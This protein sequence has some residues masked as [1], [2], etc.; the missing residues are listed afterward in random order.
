MEIL[1]NHNFVRKNK[2]HKDRSLEFFTFLYTF[3]SGFVFFKPGFYEIL[4]QILS[5][6]SSQTH[7]TAICPL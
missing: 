3:S 5:H 7:P 1:S 4:I 6:L 2:V